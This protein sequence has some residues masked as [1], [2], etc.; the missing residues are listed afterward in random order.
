M[1]RHLI[2]YIRRPDYLD[3]QAMA[4]L[5]ELVEKYPYFHAARI[6]LLRALYQLHD[7]SFDSELKKTAILIPN[8]DT[9]FFLFEEKKYQPQKNALRSLADKERENEGQDR[10]GS[11]I[12]DFLGT[13]P[14]E[15]PS[16][17]NHPI[18]PTVDY[19]GYLMQTMQQTPQEDSTMN[20]G[21]LIDEFL[22]NEKG[23]I[24]LKDETK[25]PLQKPKVMEENDAD[26]EFFTETLAQIYIKQG[27]IEQAIE[28]IKRLSLKYPKKNRYFADQ[29]RFMEKI[30]INN[31]NK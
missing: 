5:R 4:Q 10:T 14:E 28:I 23:K 3:L 30:I 21:N 9:L 29:I 24:V 12:D 2:D 8:R 22:N 7:P 18:E 26:N 19:L 27:K 1:Q 16:K 13:L 31:K 17:R 20:G 6:L 25:E 11:L 15:K